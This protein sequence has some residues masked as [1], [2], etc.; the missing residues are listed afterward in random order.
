MSRII[1][2][3]KYAGETKV[4]VFDFTSICQSLG[5]PGTMLAPVGPTTTCT[6]ALFSGVDA[7]PGAMISGDGVVNL[8]QVYQAVT[9][10]TAGN[11]YTITC[12]VRL[13]DMK[14]TV[15][16]QAHIAVTSGTP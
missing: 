13:N 14:S 8:N 2:P 9:G 15:N 1:L 10:G 6:M 5:G 3:A 11:I 12:L 7:N 16:L 4:Y